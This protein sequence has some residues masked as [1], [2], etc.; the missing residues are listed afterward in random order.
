MKQFFLALVLLLSISACEEATD[1][2]YETGEN[3]KLVVEA[4]ITNELKQQEIF[5]SLS[6]DDINGQPLPA[7]GATV[8]MNNGVN[9]VAFF[10]D[11]LQ[12]GHY[13]SEFEFA[14]QLNKDYFLDIGYAGESHHASTGIVP[15]FPIPTPTFSPAGQNDNLRTI[16]PPSAYS[17]LEQAMYEV[18]ID[19]SH[20]TNETP[21]RARQIFYTLK[22]VDVSEVFKAN[23]LEPKFPVG[24]IVTVKKY[25][26]NDDFAEYIRALLLETEWQGS[27]LD[28][29]SSSLPTNISGGAL[30]F[31][32]VCSVLETSVVVE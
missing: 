5:L 32:A 11:S 31:F 6:Y 30:G 21:N 8:M 12:S 14:T 9:E 26:L 27:I 29:S 2:D 1:W 3:S 19:W 15:V 16:N 24:S 18:D 20:L 25:S 7:S 23:Q 4:I 22:T 13:L 10:E 28:E 17:T